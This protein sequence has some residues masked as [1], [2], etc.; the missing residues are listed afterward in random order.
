L[1]ARPSLPFAVK[2][3]QTPRMRI[4][5][6]QPLPEPS[7][8][9]LLRGHEVTV[10]PE[11]PAPGEL[12]ALL[13]GA[14][15][16]L[17]TPPLKVDAV[18]LRGATE[19]RIVAQ[20]AVGI[21]NIDLVE[22]RRRGI[23]VTNTPDVLTEAT[24]DLTW[25]LILAVARR[26]PEAEALVRSGAWTGWKPTELLGISLEGKMLGIF[27]PGRI[28]R[29]VARRGAAF[30]MRILGVGSSDGPTGFET[31]LR[32]SDVIS[33]HAPMNRETAGRFGAAEFAR[34]KAG[35]I[36]VNTSRGGLMDDEALA[37]S[38]AE[39]HLRGAGLDVYPNEP[40]IHPALLH[41]P[42]AVLLPHIGSA[43]EETRLQMARLACEDI[44]R[45]LAGE[46]PEH[47]VP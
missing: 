44:R 18:A 37:A 29:A 3:A 25:A 41:S 43:T 39:G 46:P 42:R 10:L 19:L 31:L 7:I 40:G 24:A 12:A 13:H 11:L 9:E 23:V 20:C 36:F 15:A 21:D 28:G 14:A 32:E 38:L 45:V 17:S 4:L 26:M 33:L 2:S 1:V 47:A 16:L 34:M 6:A 27:G 5:V 35:A 8:G 22:C 30:G